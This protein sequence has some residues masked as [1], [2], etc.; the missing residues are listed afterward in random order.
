MF[1]IG[2]VNTTKRNLLIVCI[3]DAHFYLFF[4]KVKT[5]KS[6]RFLRLLKLVD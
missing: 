3:I 6:A 2:F 5:P 1:R 4:L